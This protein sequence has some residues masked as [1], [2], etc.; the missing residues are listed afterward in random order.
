[1]GKI[2]SGLTDLYYAQKARMTREH[3]II[4]RAI[5][6]RGRGYSVYSIPPGVL[7][8]PSRHK[9]EQLKQPWA[10]DLLLGIA[11]EYTKCARRKNNSILLPTPVANHPNPGDVADLMFYTNALEENRGPLSAGTAK[12]LVGT[13]EP[14]SYLSPEEAEYLQ[15]SMRSH[16]LHSNP[17]ASIVVKSAPDTVKRPGKDMVTSADAKNSR[18]SW[19]VADRRPKI[20]TRLTNI[21]GNRNNNNGSNGR[22]QPLTPV[23][24]PSPVETSP[25]QRKPITGLA[26]HNSY[27]RERHTDSGSVSTYEEKG[28]LGKQYCYTGSHYKLSEPPPVPVA[29]HNQANYYEDFD[30]MSNYGNLDDELDKVYRSL[31]ALTTEGSSPRSP[32]DGGVVDSYPKTEKFTADPRLATQTKLK[33]KVH[34]DDTR[35][36]L[37]PSNVTFDDLLTRVQAKFNAPN[38]IRLQYRDEDNEMVLMIDQDDLNM[39]RRLARMRGNITDS[40]EKLEFWCVS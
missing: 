40:A 36:L 12:P 8:R 3:D 15:D 25:T 39:A 22:Y 19:K 28:A 31:A 34:H 38:T 16:L 7:Y 20:D 18:D 29:Q 17:D 5:Q 21:D 1:M 11:Y 2:D 32:E 30:T 4:E 26:D 27:T 9:L 14:V 33:I 23:Q 35:I 6:N 13:H 10:N 24:G 37:V